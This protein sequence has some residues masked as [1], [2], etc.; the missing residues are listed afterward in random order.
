MMR[1]IWRRNRFRFHAL[2]DVVLSARSDALVA[3]YR[4]VEAEL[5]R[6]AERAGLGLM[7]EGR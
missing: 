6:L 2:V 3:G 5:I 4:A 1:E 7:K